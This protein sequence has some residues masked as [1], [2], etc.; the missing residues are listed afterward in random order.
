[1]FGGNDEFTL[2]PLGGL[3]SHFGKPQ[4]LQGARAKRLRAGFGLA[5]VLL[6]TAENVGCLIHQ[7]QGCRSLVV[8]RRRVKA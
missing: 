6:H 7:I 3:S 5:G 4:S 1:M 2:R 8:C